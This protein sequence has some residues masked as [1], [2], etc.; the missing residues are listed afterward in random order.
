[1]LGMKIHELG[2]KLPNSFLVYDV[3]TKTHFNTLKTNISH[4]HF[5]WYFQSDTTYG[6]GQSSTS[7]THG[8]RHCFMTADV[9]KS[10]YTE[11]VLPIVWTMADCLNKEIKSIYSIHANLVENYN[12]PHLTQAHIDIQDYG[13]DKNVWTAIFYIDDVD[14]NTVFFNNKLTET[15][16]YEQ[17]P[18]SNTMLIFPNNQYHA[19]RLPEIATFRRVININIIVNE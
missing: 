8:F 16:I 7:M 15:I 11:L 9:K 10:D 4:S 19:M 6:L 12:L 13:D 18:V 2:L 14:G 3:L 1:M 5:P 17:T